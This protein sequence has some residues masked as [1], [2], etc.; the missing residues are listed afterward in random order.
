[1]VKHSTSISDRRASIR[2]IDAYIWMHGD[3]DYSLFAL[4][5]DGDMLEYNDPALIWIAPTDEA[6]FVTEDLNIYVG[7]NPDRD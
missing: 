4:L 1:V 3:S 2:T 7:S 6:G 5:S